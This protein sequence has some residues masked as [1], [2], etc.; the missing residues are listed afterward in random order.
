MRS[1]LASYPGDLA[2]ERGELYRCVGDG[3]AGHGPRGHVTLTLFPFFLLVLNPFQPQLPDSKMNVMSFNRS[4]S[5][6]RYPEN[7][8]LLEANCP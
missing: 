7:Q 8:A 4:F 5:T 6:V 1:G 2:R 3:R